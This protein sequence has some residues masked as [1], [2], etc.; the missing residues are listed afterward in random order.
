[1]GRYIIR[2]CMYFMTKRDEKEER[3]RQENKGAHDFR[4]E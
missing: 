4:I 1:M 2:M 3:E